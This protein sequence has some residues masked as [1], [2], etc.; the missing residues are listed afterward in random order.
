VIQ[1]VLAFDAGARDECALRP[2][3]TPTY[4][5]SA[6]SAEVATNIDQ[7]PTQR[8]EVIG[9]L[10]AAAKQADAERA[11]QAETGITERVERDQAH[12]P[13]GEDGRCDG[14]G[15]RAETGASGSLSS[16]DARSQPEGGAGEIN[17][18]STCAAT[19]PASRQVTVEA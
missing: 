6:A 5:V 17:R 11:D 16:L 2:A 9:S 7:K 18:R 8:T 10:R 14:Y 19:T 4:G 3:R 13:A 12:Q 1:A 15:G